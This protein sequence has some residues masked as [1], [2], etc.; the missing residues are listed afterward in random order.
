MPRL[1]LSE[2]PPY[3]SLASNFRG[4]R[5]T[6]SPKTLMNYTSWHWA[7][8]TKKGITTIRIIHWGVKLERI[9]LE[10]DAPCPL[11]ESEICPNLT[12]ENVRHGNIYLAEMNRGSFPL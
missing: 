5:F 11:C 6:D 12:S 3:G 4:N 1:F 7:N 8:G 2:F 10:T 9:V